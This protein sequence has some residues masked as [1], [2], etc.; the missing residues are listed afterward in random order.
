MPPHD[1]QKTRRQPLNRGLIDTESS[2]RRGRD[3]Q[4]RV[5]IAENAPMIRW[6]Q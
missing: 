4:Q 3:I 2:N 1:Q 5:E 6:R